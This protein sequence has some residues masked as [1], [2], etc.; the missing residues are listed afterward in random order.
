MHVLGV[1]DPIDIRD[2][3]LTCN[4]YLRAFLQIKTVL[5]SCNVGGKYMAT[6]GTESNVA[7]NGFGT[8]DCV[9]TFGIVDSV[10]L[11]D[12]GTVDCVVLKGGE[13]KY[14]CTISCMQLTKQ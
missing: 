12:F 3:G 2:I 11:K 7:N 10:A 6:F 1:L 13:L 5:T 14:L 8:E 4:K 9:V